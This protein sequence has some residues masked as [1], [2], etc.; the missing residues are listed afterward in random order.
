MGGEAPGFVRERAAREGSE[1]SRLKD[2]LAARGLAPRK[3]WGQNFLVREELAARIAEQ[4][5]LKPDD[6]VVEIGPGAGAL[7]PHLVTR[8]AHVVAVEKDTGLADYLREAIGE[9]PHLDIVN[10]D[11]LEFDLAATAAAHGVE[12]LVVVGN[13]P[14]N[15]TTP[16]LIRVF[17]QRAV[18]RT[19][20]LLVQKEYAER[21]AAAADTGAYG[22]LTLFARYHAQMEPMMHVR[23]SA[24]WPRPE[25]DSTLVRFFLRQTPPVDAPSED[26]LFRII[27]GSFQQRRK[28]LGNTLMDSLGVGR[29]QVETI[30]RIARI[31]PSRR[32]ET[33]TLEEFA[34]L[35]W[36]A[37]DAGVVDRG[38]TPHQND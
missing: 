24:F 18:I 37:V 19:A 15:I 8:V 5:H 38:K 1:L 13:I 3:R 27:R 29:E 31:T 11:F 20:V 23:A 16:I 14:Y 12:R 9:L 17:E 34:R 32:G 25:V 21:L 33:L 22:S 6:V 28:Q 26:L 2:A 36:A 35:A 7:T 30:A 4:C 10:A